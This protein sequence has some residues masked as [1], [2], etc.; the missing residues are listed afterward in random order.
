V[1][2]T[3]A[4]QTADPVLTESQS[5]TSARLVL[6]SA[7]VALC[8]I[9]DE[10]RPTFI[11][12]ACRHLLGLGA[13]PSA[14]RW[15]ERAHPDDR[16]RVAATWTS[17]IRQPRETQL[18]YRTV[19][20]GGEDRHLIERV[21]PLDGSGAGFVATIT[22]DSRRLAELA[23]GEDH[24]RRIEAHFKETI[25]RLPIGIAHADS[26]YRAC[27]FNSAFCLMLGYP[28]EELT[29]KNFF[30]MTHPEDVERS[31]TQ[32]AQ[33]E[34]GK[35]KRYTIEKRYVRKDGSTVWVRATVGISYDMNGEHDG[36][37]S[38]FE[39]ITLRKHAE[40]EVERIHRELMHAS[41]Q[42][43]MAEVAT[44]VLH[45]VGNVLNSLNVSA[46]LASDQ[47]R[48]LK[49]DSLARVVT[50]LNEQQERL[51]EFFSGD[52]RARQLPAFLEK[53]C[54][55]LQATR[56]TCLSELDSLRRNVEHIKAIVATQQ[57]YA[58]RSGMTETVEVA[59]LV[60]DSLAM[61]G[62]ALAR[63]GIV[64]EREFQAVPPITVS[65]HKVLQILVNLERNAK[66]ACEQTGRT[67]KRITVR[68]ERIVA[69]I[70]IQVIDNGIGIDARHLQRLFTHGFTTRTDGHGFGLHSA[71]LA[72]KELG[73]A[74]EAYSAGPGTGATFTLT[75]PLTPPPERAS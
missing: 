32:W 70:R 22:D 60:E 69:G 58:T 59:A 56:D 7:P 15:L 20:S 13:V 72:A 53:L 55:H 21:T 74:L 61:N 3:S 26:Q 35:V 38:V 31:K 71:S 49:I 9:D 29:G 66:H 27:W 41:H 51:G 65:K 52:A 18:E 44:N 54:A 43:G 12:A 16:S 17:L 33:M 2:G 47:T 36:H 68:I 34:S 62:A 30:E 24:R 37:T 23:A 11:N 5:D 4:H 50:L 28:A 67:D 39:D 64:L 45:N 19:T 42:A 10:G 48:S 8:Q 46:D 73:G 57:S 6:E 63:H 14:Q 40:L 75:L 1:A 25:E